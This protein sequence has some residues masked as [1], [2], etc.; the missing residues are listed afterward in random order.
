MEND[1]QRLLARIHGRV[2]G[3]SFR[4]FT[5]RAAE[6]L[7]LTGWVRNRFDGTVEL[8]AEG[9]KQILIQFIE[10]INQGSGM[11]QVVNIEQRWDQASGEFTK[12]SISATR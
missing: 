2:Q 10:I 11:A 7:G 3:V 5:L 6:Q 8:V 1:Q 9:E 12:F 4:Y